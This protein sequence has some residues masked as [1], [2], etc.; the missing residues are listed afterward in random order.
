MAARGLVSPGEPVIDQGYHYV[1]PWLGRTI[2]VFPSNALYLHC[3]P[4]IDYARNG[5]RE[6]E[7]HPKGHGN[8]IKER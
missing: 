5:G 6:W 7:C 8:I 2:W 1:S 3:Q 4:R